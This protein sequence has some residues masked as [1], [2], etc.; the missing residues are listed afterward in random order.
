MNPGGD[1]GDPPQ[2]LDHSVRRPVLRA[3]SNSRPRGRSYSNPPRIRNPDGID[4]VP[5]VDTS[6]AR[7][8]RYQPLMASRRYHGESVRLHRSPHTADVRERGVDQPR[9][10]GER[11]IPERSQH[12]LVRNGDADEQ[13]ASP[14][15]PGPVLK[16]RAP[17]AAFG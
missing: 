7:R 6:D 9:E 16:K 1:D 3:S 8:I 15:S 4:D 5:V 11:Q 10:F 14:Y 2:P 13:V 17:L 12:P